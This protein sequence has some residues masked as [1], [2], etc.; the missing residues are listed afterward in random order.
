MSPT[1]YRTAPPRVEVDPEQYRTRSSFAT[2][3]TGA[4]ETDQPRGELRHRH[5]AEMVAR[6]DLQ[7][8][9]G[10]AAARS[11][12][13]DASASLSPTI[14][15]VVALIS[16]S[17]ILELCAD[18][19]WAASASRSA[20]VVSANRRNARAPGSVIVDGSSASMPSTIALRSIGA[21]SSAPEPGDPTADPADHHPPDPPFGR[22][23]DHRDDGPHRVAG[24]VEGLEVERVEQLDEVGAHPAF[25]VG[26]PGR[27]ACRWLHDH[28]R[29][30]RRHGDHRRAVHRRCQE[31]P[32]STRCRLRTRVGAPRSEGQALPSPARTGGR[33]SRPRR[34]S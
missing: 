3:S 31:P 4:E 1:S 5:G 13:R 23:G 32:S 33:R 29:R 2:P 20:P 6:H 22:R 8:Q 14:N 18:C 16:S 19:I 28:A 15:R 27:V 24:Q 26:R 30:P 17:A 7:P 25:A 12:G 34:W 10:I 11:S 21:R 9:P